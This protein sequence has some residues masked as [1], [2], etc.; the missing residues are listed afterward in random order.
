MDEKE[1]EALITE[2]EHTIAKLRFE[3]P[4]STELSSEEEV[5]K[6]AKQLLAEKRN[7]SRSSDEDEIT[8]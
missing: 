8:F 4:R 1:L 7:T 6:D 3:K 2:L 5:L